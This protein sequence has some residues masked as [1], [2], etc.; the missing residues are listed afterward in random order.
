MHATWKVSSG[1]LKAI[2]GRA[3]AVAT[4]SKT[5]TRRNLNSIARGCARRNRYNI[6]STDTGTWSDPGRYP[7]PDPVTAMAG[8]TGRAPLTST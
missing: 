3:Q 6:N 5:Q 8:A 1:D 7:P 4:T 2:G